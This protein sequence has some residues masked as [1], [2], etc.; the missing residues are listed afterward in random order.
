MLKDEVFSAPMLD[1]LESLRVVMFVEALE[2][3]S[4]AEGVAR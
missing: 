4:L 2:M 1:R 3:S